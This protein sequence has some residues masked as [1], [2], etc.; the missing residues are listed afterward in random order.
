MNISKLARRI[1]RG[2]IY[3]LIALMAIVLVLDKIGIDMT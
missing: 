1:E 3:T 2:I